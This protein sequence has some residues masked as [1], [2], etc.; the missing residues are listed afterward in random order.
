MSYCFLKA[1][2]LFKNPVKNFTLH[3]GFDDALRKINLVCGSENAPALAFFDILSE[4]CLIKKINLWRFNKLLTC[5][6]ELKDQQGE[7]GVSCGA[8]M[9]ALSILIKVC[10]KVV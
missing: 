8:T 1:A 3:V 4:D 9:W 6:R 7:R 2:S 10:T 5:V